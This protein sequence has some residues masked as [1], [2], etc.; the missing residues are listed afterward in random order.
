MERM[1]I[2]PR[3]PCTAAASSEDVFD[4]AVSAL[5]MAQAVG[6][7]VALDAEPAYAVEGKIWHPNAYLL[8]RQA[9]IW[10][11]SDPG[12]KRGPGRGLVASP[13]WLV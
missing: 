10:P 9:R 2:A 11:R 7:L 6:E 13:K 4:T 12:T 5:V 1:A 8:G 3:V